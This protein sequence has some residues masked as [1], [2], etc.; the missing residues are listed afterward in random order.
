MKLLYNTCEQHHERIK[1]AQKEIAMEELTAFKDK[2]RP[3]YYS[4]ITTCPECG[5]EIK[6][7]AELKINFTIDGFKL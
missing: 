2:S 1:N 3:V 5:Q 6:I 7:F 4:K